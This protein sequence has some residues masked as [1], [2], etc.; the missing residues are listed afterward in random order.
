MTAEMG[1]LRE[2]FVKAV[3]ARGK[4]TFA[5]LHRFRTKNHPED[6]LGCRLTNHRFSSSMDGD[7]VIVT[8][9]YDIHVWYSYTTGDDFE[10]GP[11][12]VQTAVSVQTVEF[13]ERVPVQYIDGSSRGVANPHCRLTATRHPRATEISLDADG[14]VQVA[15]EDGY[16]TEV[17]ADTTLW[18][19]VYAAGDALDDKKKGFELWEAAD[20]EWDDEFDDELD[21]IEDDIVSDVHLS[22]GDDGD[23]KQPVR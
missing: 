4:R 12:R 16:A 18:V 10:G 22:A 7:A 8:G 19:P 17:I 6:L 13:Q 3:C 15:V 20:G 9:S 23:E 21:Q 14:V 2:I 5:R 11:G 1:T